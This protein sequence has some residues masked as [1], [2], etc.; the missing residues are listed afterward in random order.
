MGSQHRPRS[1]AHVN[2]TAGTDFGVEQERRG[3]RAG[4]ST[5]GTGDR[6][7]TDD[8]VNRVEQDVLCFPADRV[9]CQRHADRTAT[10]ARGVDRHRINRRRVGR[11]HHDITR[12]GRGHVTAGDRGRGPALHHVGRRQPGDRHFCAAAKPAAAFR[13]RGGR[14]VCVGREQRRFARRHAHV[15][16]R[17][18]HRGI[19]N[20][21]RG[22]TAHIIERHRKG[23]SIG[24]G[25]AKVAKQIV[26]LGGRVGLEQDRRVNVSAVRGR[27]RHPGARTDHPGAGI[28]VAV[29]NRGFSRA[30]HL[31]LRDHRAKAQA[32]R[33]K[34]TGCARGR[35]VFNARRQARPRGGIDVNATGSIDLG[36]E[37]ER[38]GARTRVVAKSIGDRR[39][40]DDGV[41]GVEQDVLRFPADRVE[42]QRHTN[43]TATRAR[44][45]HRNGM[46]RRRVGRTHHDIT[47]RGRGHVTAGDRGRGRA[48]HHVG[49][50]KPRHP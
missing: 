37:Q 18:R 21:G 40:T 27:H 11:T 46:N 13:T 50:R 6:R 29:V 8:G 36:V 45:V 24:I 12:C 19:G 34:G 43:R 10:R 31:V 32:R 47:R 41:N 3:A 42:R 33:V 7:I 49:R 38:R 22:A 25:R 23:H 39:I 9:E 20:R 35:A 2:G 4:I 15:T 26:R 5:E 16:I 17:H 28:R 30:A 44:G 48:L 14:D 1:G